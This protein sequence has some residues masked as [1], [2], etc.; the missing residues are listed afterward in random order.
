M[1]DLSTEFF[2]LSSPLPL[3]RLSRTWVELR[4]AGVSNYSLTFGALGAGQEKSTTCLKYMRTADRKTAPTMHLT[5][6]GQ[7]WESLEG[8]IDT[9]KRMKVRRVLA[10]RGDAFRPRNDGPNSCVELIEFLTDHGLKTSVAAYPDGH[11]DAADHPRH[12][13]AGDRTS[14]AEWLWRK[15]DA[16]ADQVITQFSA[17]ID[18]ILTLRDSLAR[19]GAPIDL[20]VGVMPIPEWERFK[21]LMERCGITPDAGE[22]LLFDGLPEDS[23]TALS[24]GLAYANMRALIVEGCRSFHLYGLNNSRILLPLIRSLQAFESPAPPL[25]PRAAPATHCA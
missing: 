25:S 18:G 23:H 2:P 22:D 13:E 15:L 20:K 11:P 9:W 3:Q 5:C 4:Q 1:L 14:E 8:L 12:D 10:L 17:R 24:L 6:R 7:T 19:S 16:G 21:T